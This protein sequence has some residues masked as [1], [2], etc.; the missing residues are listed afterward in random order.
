[1]RALIITAPGEVS[2]GTAADPQV[3]VGEVLLRPRIVGYCGSDLNTFR[4]NNPLVAYPRIPG[5]EIAATIE[6]VG[7]EVPACW[8]PGLTVTVSPYLGC[9]TCSAC[10]VGRSN[11]CAVNRTLGVQCE[12]GLCDLLV[13][14]HSKL[15]S[16]PRLSLRELAMVE[17]LTIG[18]HAVARGQIAADDTVA[19]LGA[20][21]IGLGVIAAAARAG[22]RVI[23][24]DLDEAKLDMARACG[25]AEVIAAGREDVAGRIRELTAGEGPRVTVEAIGLPATFQLAVDVACHAGTVVY[26][27]YAK[28]PVEYDT[29]QFILKELDIRG[30]RNALPR[31]FE[32][33]IAMLEAGAFPLDQAITRSVPLAEG[34]AALREWSADPAAVTKIQVVL[35]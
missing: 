8:Q 5:H 29:K 20:G 4:G 6:A 18:A 31:D 27:G 26:I 12:G 10:R 25:A 16:S 7:P 19:V 3:G 22:G 15:V 13:M 23:A 11:C 17:P 2:L 28:L 34:P 21:T 32:S 24:V 30:S 14:P 35:D 33:V 1:M 9:G